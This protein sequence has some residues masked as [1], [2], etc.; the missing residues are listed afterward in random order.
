MSAPEPRTWVTEIGY[1]PAGTGPLQFLHS[2][3]TEPESLAEPEPELEA[4]LWP[5]STSRTR[6]ARLQKDP[7]FTRT[8][9]PRHLRRL[10]S[11]GSGSPC[12]GPNWRQNREPH[13]RR[14]RRQLF[15]P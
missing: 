3:M 15:H 1:P 6:I 4:G 9:L 8:T 13:Q 11:P 5:L 10:P 14:I 7:G 2:H 12:P